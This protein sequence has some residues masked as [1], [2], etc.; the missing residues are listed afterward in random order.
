L[1]ILEAEKEWKID[2]L[3]VPKLNGSQLGADDNLNGRPAN[4]PEDDADSTAVV[5]KNA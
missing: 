1:N 3:L 5:K 4:E 2:D